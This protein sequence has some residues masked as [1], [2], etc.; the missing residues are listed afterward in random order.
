MS[1][2]DWVLARELGEYGTTV[3]PLTP[4]L[5]IAPMTAGVLP[6][7]PLKMQRSLRS[8]HRDE[9]PA[10]LVGTL[11]FLAS[12]EAAFFTGQTVNVDAGLYFSYLGRSGTV[13]SNALPAAGY[14]TITNARV[15]DG[16]TVLEA[17][18]VTI[19]DGVISAIGQPPP[20]DARVI[21]GRGGTLLPG[22][23]DA[24]V[25]PTDQGLRQALTFGVTTVVEMGGAPRSHEDRA[26][27][28]ADDELADI[29][30]AGLPLTAVC[31]HPNELF[32]SR[33]E[34]ISPDGTWRP[35]AA[36]LPG[37]S[38]P[39]DLPEFIAQRVHEGSDFIKL[40][41]EEGTVLAFPGLPEL[42]QDVFAAAV[43]EAHDHGKVVVAHALTYDAT[44]A[45]IGAG[46]DGLSHIFLDVPRTDAIVDAIAAAGIFVIPCLVLNRSITGTT[47][48]DLAADARVSSRLDETWLRALR[49]SFNTW[50]DGDF[51]SSLRTVGALHRAGVPILA[52]TDTAVPE[53]EHGGLAQG[54]SLHHELQLLVQAGLSP[55]EA[56]RAA[57]AVPAHRFG[58]DDRGVIRDGARADLVLV[59]GD[60]TTEITDTLATRAVWRRGAMTTPAVAR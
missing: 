8:F 25:H 27:I 19:A 54:A 7:A 37:L 12:D 50:P 1:D 51:A 47:G 21:D 55:V 11:C 28:A 44:L 57:T 48:K 14:Y 15:F 10:D 41:A 46:V 43:R 2:R 52:G 40:L 59:D 42:S 18:T 58:L 39:A 26:R 4:G 16:E 20:P 45:M 22:L 29:R 56:L 3:D 38:D 17:D 13:N 30:S 31:G 34:L 53:E 33:E 32:V 6:E 36:R 9:V 23:I 60:P 49:S 35:E 24:H 5:T